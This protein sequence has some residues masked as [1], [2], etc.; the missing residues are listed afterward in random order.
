MYL[1]KGLGTQNTEETSACSL[2][3]ITYYILNQASD[4]FSVRQQYTS[5]RIV[6]QKDHVAFHFINQIF[7]EL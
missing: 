4:L 6:Y 5:K 3:S 7:C 1:K 2:S